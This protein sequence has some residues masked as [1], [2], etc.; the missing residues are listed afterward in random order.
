[1][2]ELLGGVRHHHERW[3]GSGY[4]VGLKG[5]SIPELGRLV[6]VVDAFDAM[7]SARAYR[8]GRNSETVRA[9]IERCAGT[10][11]DPEMAMA[12]LKIDLA[13]YD[14]MLEQTQKSS[15]PP[16]GDA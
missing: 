14:A 4:P 10:H 6:A 9:E 15:Q 5:D 7:R 3:D 1:M 2:G 12:F 8:E 16:E 11:F 13:H